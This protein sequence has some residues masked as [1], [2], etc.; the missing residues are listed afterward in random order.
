MI[1][2][3]GGRWSFPFEAGVAL[4]GAPTL[5]VN[6]G[7]WVCYDQTQ[8]ECADIASTTDPIAISV[9]AT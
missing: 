4:V 7:G 9:K 5:K 1:P 2:R 3:K 8:T 6:L